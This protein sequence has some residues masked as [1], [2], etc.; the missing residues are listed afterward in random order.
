MGLGAQG[1]IAKVRSSSRG[2]LASDRRPRVQTGA[3]Y[4]ARSRE[5]DETPGVSPKG[6]ARSSP[7][8]GSRGARAFRAEER[9]PASPR[10]RT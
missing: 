5:R 8:E 2:R 7:T 6:R 9:E 4:E 3:A 10:R 1:I